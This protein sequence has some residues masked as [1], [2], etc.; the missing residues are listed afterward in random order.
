MQQFRREAARGDGRVGRH[1]LAPLAQLRQVG[2]HQGRALP[3]EELLER[4]AR[5]GRLGAGRER[6]RRGEGTLRLRDPR[7]RAGVLLDVQRVHQQAR[8]PREHQP[9]RS[10]EFAGLIA[11]LHHQPGERLE[12]VG[13]RERRD[14][15]ALHRPLAGLV[16][17]VAH[18][19]EHDATQVLGRRRIGQALVLDLAAHVGPRQAA[20]GERPARR[21]RSRLLHR[22]VLCRRDDETLRNPGR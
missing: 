20:L 21:A 12:E 2:A 19:G 4:G 16:V 1:G 14:D 15:R 7:E 8:P 13:V 9:L 6:G 17:V 5:R 18:G 10:P 3:P 22:V 11:G